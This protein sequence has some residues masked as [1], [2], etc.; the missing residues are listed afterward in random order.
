MDNRHPQLKPIFPY[1]VSIRGSNYVIVDTRNGN[2]QKPAYI[3][4]SKAE[5]ACDE[6]NKQA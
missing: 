1:A 3:T 2:I 5:K 4:R 6:L